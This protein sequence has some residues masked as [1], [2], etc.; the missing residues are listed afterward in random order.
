MACIIGPE[1]LILILHAQVEN[2][3]YVW[4][5]LL[6][7]E[8][9]S[10]YTLQHADSWRP[11]DYSNQARLPRVYDRAAHVADTGL[12][13]AEHAWVDSLVASRK[14]EQDSTNT[15]STAAST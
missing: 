7:N 5:P 14:K 13:A 3:T 1:V 2:A 9:G 8:D 10:G 12:S 4:L 15:V 6:P 11:S